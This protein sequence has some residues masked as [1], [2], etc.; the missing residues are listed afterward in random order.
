MMCSSPAAEG[1]CSAVSRHAPA[2]A[3]ALGLEVAAEAVDAPHLLGPWDTYGIIRAR[4]V[5]TRCLFQ[6]GSSERIAS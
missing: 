4:P 2:P 5:F 6:V 3:A 1:R